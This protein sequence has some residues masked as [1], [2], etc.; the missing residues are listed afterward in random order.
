MAS[1]SHRK[2]QLVVILADQQTYGLFGP[3]GAF[4][5]RVTDAEADLLDSGSKLDELPRPA[6]TCLQVR[7][8]VLWAAGRLTP[9]PQAKA[10]LDSVAD[11]I[12]GG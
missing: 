7:D 5:A 4:V 3:A 1:R 10:L 8:L 12:L 6:D 11:E 2:H 9:G